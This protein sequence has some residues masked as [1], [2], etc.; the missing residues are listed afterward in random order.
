MGIRAERQQIFNY[1][2]IYKN[3]SFSKTENSFSFS[4]QLKMLK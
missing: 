3:I 1:S 4:G 2:E